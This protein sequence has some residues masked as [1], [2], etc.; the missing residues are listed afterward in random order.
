MMEG[1]DVYSLKHETYVYWL[2]VLKRTR[3]ND[4]LSSNVQFSS[5]IELSD[6]ISH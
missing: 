1:N 2:H 4:Q 5:Q 6:N 3:N